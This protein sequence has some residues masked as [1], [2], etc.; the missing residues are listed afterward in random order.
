MGPYG[1]TVSY[2]RCTERIDWLM[3]VKIEVYDIDSSNI[4]ATLPLLNLDAS[5]KNAIHSAVSIGH[6]VKVH[7]DTLTVQNWQ[8]AGYIDLDP[9]TNAGGYIISGGWAGGSTT[10]PG[11]GD[12]GGPGDGGTTAGDPVNIANGNLFHT[13]LDYALPAEA[14]DIDITRHY[15][16]MVGTSGPF[17]QGWTYSYN[18]TIEEQGDGSVIYT[19]G[20]GAIYLYTKNPDDSYQRPA[21]MFSE[22]TISGGGFLIREKDGTSHNFDLS[23]RLTSIVDRNSN[24]LT[25]TYSGDQLTE[26]NEPER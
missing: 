10:G 14:R 7:Q 22:L 6:K 24:Q 3:E 23:G 11:G 26:I 9:T 8:G 18:E 12:A 4:A 25:F 21:G 1:D 5:V 16:S 2:G 20:S 17:G 13:E 15:N 19:D